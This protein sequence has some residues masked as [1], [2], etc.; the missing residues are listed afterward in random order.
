MTRQEAWQQFRREHGEVPA[1][2]IEDLWREFCAQNGV[3][4]DAIQDPQETEVPKRRGR[5]PGSKN[6]VTE[7]AAS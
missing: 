6:R 2:Q 5:P 4:P 7:P 1:K 3:H